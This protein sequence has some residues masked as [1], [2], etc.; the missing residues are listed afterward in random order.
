MGKNTRE[1]SLIPGRAEEF[2]FDPASRLALETLQHPIRRF[3][4]D[5]HR[6]KGTGV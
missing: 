6:G 5:I 4:N 3:W 2:L 1:W